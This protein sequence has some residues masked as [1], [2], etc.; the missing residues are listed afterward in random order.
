ME[1]STNTLIFTATY[2]II[3]LIATTLSIILYFNVNRYADIAFNYS[4]NMDSSIINSEITNDK[5]RTNQRKYLNQDEVFSYYVNYV[6]KDLYDTNVNN[7]I[8]YNVNIIDPNSATASLGENLSYSEV[9]AKLDGCNEYYLEYV[10]E[11]INGNTKT[12]NI[13]IG[14]IRE[15]E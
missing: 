1:S 15:S 13:T 3:F 4:K 9:K 11:I 12:V 10:E 2:V 7:D 5:P 14:P 6:K 8:N